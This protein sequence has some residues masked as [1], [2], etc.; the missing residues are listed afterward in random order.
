MKCTSPVLLGVHPVP[1]G[2]CQACRINRRRVWVHRM[3]LEAGQYKDN[4][5]V[6][7]TYSPEN[8]PDGSSLEP[9]HTQD[10]LKRFRKAI[11]PLRV[12]YYLVGEYGEQ[13][14]RPLL[15]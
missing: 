3:M 14:W 2:Q 12:R 15:S 6:T 11:A 5:F 1:C 4:T 8:E 10:W 13:S 9:K 7:L